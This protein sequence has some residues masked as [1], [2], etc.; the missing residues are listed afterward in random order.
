MPSSLSTHNE[1]TLH[2]ALKDWAS[3]PGDLLEAPLDG[4]TIDVLRQTPAGVDICIEIQT[5]NFTHLKRKLT[6]LLENGRRV[7]LLHPIPAQKWIIRQTK[8]GDPLGRRQ[9]PKRGQYADVFKELVRIPEI[10]PHPNFTLEILLTQQEEIWQDD[11]QGSWR[12]KHWSKVDHRLLKVLSAH[13]FDSPA[14]YLTLL[15]ADLPRPFT[16]RQLA[17][18]IKCPPGLAG[19]ITYTLEKA[20]WLEPA[21]KTG[22]AKLFTVRAGSP[23]PAG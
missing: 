8:D 3:L 13:R 2:A 4:Y 20:G 21:G 11:G 10:L 19:K 22:N 14:D 1:S 23:R 12:R 17:I 16:N 6:T 18:A 9:S 7:H 5:G 15:P